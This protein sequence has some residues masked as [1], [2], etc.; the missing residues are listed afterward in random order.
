MRAG[1]Y[2]AG[3]WRRRGSSALPLDGR[4]TGGWAALSI[5]KLVTAYAGMCLR[6]R[7]SS[8]NAESDI[9]FVSNVVD[10]STMLAFCGASDGFVVNIYDQFGLGH[11]FFQTA[12][13]ATQ[14]KIVAA[15]VYLG[16]IV[17]DGVDDIL[18]STTQSTSP[19][20]PALSIFL[21]GTDRSPAT[22]QVPYELSQDFSSQIGGVLA[23]VASNYLS[24]VGDVITNL[25]LMF[26]TVLSGT[27]MGSRF[28]RTQVAPSD[29]INM[30]MSGVHLTAFSTAGSMTFAF[31]APNTWYLGSRSSALPCALDLT[32]FVIYE[33]AL[34]DADMVA[35]SIALA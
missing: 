9:G 7:R 8:D 34:V 28:D 31:F 6:V 12:S 33:A 14:P 5:N 18:I 30:W 19:S 29:I 15:G 21:R 10:V 4:T 24:A 20:V 17:F 11:F 13:L 22:T 32:T 26:A 25:Q 1:P 3:G 23:S 27:V 2:K 35:Y 16:K